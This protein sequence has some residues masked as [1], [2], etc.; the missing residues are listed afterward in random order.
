MQH[1]DGGTITLWK[2][3]RDVGTLVGSAPPDRM[4]QLM[5]GDMSWMTDVTGLIRPRRRSGTASAVVVV[6]AATGL[7]AQQAGVHHA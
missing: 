4:E 2:D 6:E 7:A 3:H 1:V 5:A